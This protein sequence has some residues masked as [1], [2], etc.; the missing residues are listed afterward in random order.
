MLFEIDKIY[1]FHFIKLSI[2][3]LMSFVAAIFDIKIIT[4]S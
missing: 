4:V 2:I 1:Y 3:L